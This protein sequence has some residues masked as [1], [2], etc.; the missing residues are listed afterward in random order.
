MPHRLS[1]MVRWNGQKD[2]LLR[3]IAVPMKTD[4]RRIGCNARGLDAKIFCAAFFKKAAAF[5]EQ[6]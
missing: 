6:R 2:G 5:L 4:L 1:A 3:S